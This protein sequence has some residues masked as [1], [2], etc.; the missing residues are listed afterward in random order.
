MELRRDLGLRSL[1]LAVVTGTIGS[2]WLLASYFAA[3]S[4]GAA[5]LPA[6][7]IGGVIAFLL[8]LVFA[9]LGSRINSSGALAQIPLL[10]HGSAQVAS[11]QPQWRA[12]GVHQVVSPIADD[13]LRP[14][15]RRGLLLVSC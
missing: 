9:E 8:A 13:Q 4:A 7:L 1:T 2:G 5:S 10:S 3:R 12:Q 11:S 14:L 6:W 15:L